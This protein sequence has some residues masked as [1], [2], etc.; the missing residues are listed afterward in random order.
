MNICNTHCQQHN[1]HWRQSGLII[2]VLTTDF[3]LC[4]QHILFLTWFAQLHPFYKQ[5]IN[6]IHTYVIHVYYWAQSIIILASYLV[7]ACVIV[8]NMKYTDNL[9]LQVLSSC[10]TGNMNWPISTAQLNRLILCTGQ[11]SQS[12]NLLFYGY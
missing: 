1:H 9:N 11:N 5:H 2:S 3:I 10:S 12:E 8:Q 7:T 6:D 4:S